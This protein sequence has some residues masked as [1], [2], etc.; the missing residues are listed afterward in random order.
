MGT[1][2]TSIYALVCHRAHVLQRSAMGS[3]LHSPGMGAALSRMAAFVLL[4]SQQGLLRLTMNP[5]GRL[6]CN[7]DRDRVCANT[8]INAL[9]NAAPTCAVKPLGSD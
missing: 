7:R 6:K 1:C 4:F 2:H 3:K 5:L 9:I 8:Q